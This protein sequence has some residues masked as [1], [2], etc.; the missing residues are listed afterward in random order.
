MSSLFFP[1]TIEV[2]QPGKFRL[3]NYSLTTLE[4]VM[5]AFL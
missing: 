5:C 1:A 3:P 2:F 4:N